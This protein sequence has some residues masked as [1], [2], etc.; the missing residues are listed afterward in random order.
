VVNFAVVSGFWRG[1]NPVDEARVLALRQAERLALRQ[2]EPPGGT[3]DPRLDRHK[4]L[5]GRDGWLFLQNDAND[6][7][8]QYTGHVRLSRRDLRRWWRLLARRMDTAAALDAAWLHVIVPE[9][10]ATYP[11]LLPDG[12]AAAARRPVDEILD[13]AADLGA[14]VLYPLEE[15][16]AAKTAG[17]P[18]VFCATD[19][20]FTQYGAFIVYQTTCRE[21]RASGVDVDALP[22]EAI[23][24]REYR[25][26]GDLGSKLEPAPTSVN[27]RAVVRE[28]RAR[29]VFDNQVLNHGRAMIFERDDGAGPRAVVFGQSSSNYLL[30]FLKES[31][32]RVAFLHTDTMPR[33]ILARERPDVIL[34]IPGERFIV[35]VPDDASAMPQIAETIQ[36]KRERGT[37]RPNPG[38]FLRDVPGADEVRNDFEL[39]WPVAAGE[40]RPGLA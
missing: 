36:I 20:H 14:P 16:R 40:A 24:W 4:V 3:G 13:L 5:I 6:V 22:A 19:I 27:V 17:G 29:L 25:T 7:I 35:R 1:T 9:K 31:F 11:E 12:V 10:I 37:L 23:R 28:P 30:T 8:D 33:E 2:V 15:L 18:A 21:L 34:T 39:P 26:T 38:W 32:S